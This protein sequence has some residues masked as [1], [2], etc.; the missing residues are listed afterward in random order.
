M[1][2]DAHTPRV[3][4]RRHNPDYNEQQEI[5]NYIITPRVKSDNYA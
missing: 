2:N 5:M 3:V 4:A 1:Q